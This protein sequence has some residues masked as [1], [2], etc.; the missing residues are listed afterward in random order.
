MKKSLEEFQEESLKKKR[1]GVHL[2]IPRETLNKLLYQSLK[3]FL[4]E[5]PKKSTKGF[6]EE[7][8]EKFL[9]VS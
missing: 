7:S 9:E 6:L 1:A 8:L 5:F 3:T 4:Q 2:R